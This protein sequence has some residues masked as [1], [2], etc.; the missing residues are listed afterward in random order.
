MIQIRRRDSVRSRDSKARVVVMS[1][2]ASTSLPSYVIG[3]TLY[4][5]Y[6]SSY[7]AYT[8]QRH[9]LKRRGYHAVQKS[10]SYLFASLLAGV[11]ELL[12]RAACA[13]FS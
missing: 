8:D 9:H 10:V 5:R 13:V 3:K 7:G 4:S 12:N 1:S 2:V 6:L 11:T